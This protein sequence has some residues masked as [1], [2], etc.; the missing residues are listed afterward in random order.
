MTNLG[1]ATLTL[2]P[3]AA[4]LINGAA[5]LALLPG[6]SADCYRSGAAWVAVVAAP[7]VPAG[8]VSMFAGATA[9][10]TYR[11]CDG[12]L[13]SRTTFAPLFTAIGTAWGAGDG[14]T[15]FALPDLRGRV[16]IGVGTGSGLTARALAASGG[17]ETHTMTTAEMPAHTH[18]LI[19]NAIQGGSNFSPS[20]TTDFSSRPSA[21]VT[22]S[23]GG[24]G[25]HNNMQPFNGINFII[26]T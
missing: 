3:N 23:T 7:G 5:T 24:G 21:F 20:A 16:P 19:G 8:T 14:S 1:T 6:E 22:D 26:K 25:A 17:A 2:D 18:P 9:P 10:A 13:V 12:A 4:E 11:F 15:T